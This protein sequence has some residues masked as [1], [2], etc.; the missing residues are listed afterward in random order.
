M[1]QLSNGLVLETARDM[2]EE[3]K[4]HIVH[5]HTNSFI[6]LLHFVQ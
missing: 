6:P 4:N 3:V 1:L 2:A 5:L